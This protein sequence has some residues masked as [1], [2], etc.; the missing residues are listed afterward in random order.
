[1][2]KPSVRSTT[3]APVAFATSQNAYACEQF[4]LQAELLLATGRMDEAEQN[5]LD[6]LTTARTQGAR[7]LELRAARAYANFQAA[8]HRTDEAVATLRPVV[9]QITEGRDTLD[10]V[11]AE[12][13]LEAL[14]TAGTQSRTRRAPGTRNL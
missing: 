3:P 5:Y 12:T 6:A 7:W 14:G 1:M 2:P 13:L 8:Q 4:R 9:I 11:Y 10:Y